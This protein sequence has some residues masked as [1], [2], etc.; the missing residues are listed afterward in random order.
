MGAVD[1]AIWRP[2]IA[3]KTT[4]E[5]I[6]RHWSVDDLA[7]CHDAMDIDQEMQEQLA[8]KVKGSK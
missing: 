5:E 2:I 3:K 8:P 6:E 7:D 1:W 4:L